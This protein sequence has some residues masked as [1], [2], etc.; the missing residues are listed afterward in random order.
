MSKGKKI[1]GKSGGP[2]KT[3]TTVADEPL[4]FVNRGLFDDPF[5][6]D[7]LPE[8]KNQPKNNSNSFLKDH[9]QLDGLTEFSAAFEDIDE[10]WKK[11]EPLMEG[12]SEPQLEEHF[13]KK[14]FN[15]LGWKFEVQ[16]RL[17]RRNK[18]QIP[19]YS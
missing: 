8:L 3:D 6:Q 16:D 4:Y 19:D 14:V 5:L 18:T 11:Y 13:I 2:F 9:W 17:K 12:W 1:K 15:I 7:H 10:L